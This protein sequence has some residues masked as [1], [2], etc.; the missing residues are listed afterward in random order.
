[1]KRPFFRQVAI[2]LSL[3]YL[4]TDDKTLLFVVKTSLIGL[5]LSIA[6]LLVV[7]GVI[8]GFQRDLEQRVLS[9]VPHVVLSRE[10]GLS[11]ELGDQVASRVPEVASHAAVVQTM[12]LASTDTEVH[13]IQL[14]GID[15]QIHQ[16]FTD[17]SPLRDEVAWDSLQSGAFRIVLGK[18]LAK[19]LDVDIGDQVLV[20]MAS[21]E[22]SPLG[23]F[24]RQKKFELV[25]LA[26]TESS[27]DSL[28]SYLHREDAAKLLKLQEDANAVYFHLVDPLLVNQTLFEIY[29]AANE[30]DLLASNWQSN[31][32]ALYEFLV[33][34]KQLLFLMLALLLI[35]ATFNLVSSMVMLVQSRR[36]DIAVLRTLGGNTS[37][38]LMSFVV[39]GL[40]ISAI[41][42]AAA[43]VLAY[44]LGLLLPTLYGWLSLLLG[45]TLGDS[46]AL[47][48]LTVVFQ[49][50]DLLRVVVL[51]VTMVAAGSLYP[52][53]R[54]TQLEPA[55]ILR[56][57]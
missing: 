48:R 23:F 15:P 19:R 11:G 42:L 5:V 18:N 37:L 33:R 44:L 32:G 36:D 22:I 27:L 29:L 57:D 28:I 45:V 34:F 7:Q 50:D 2:L 46:F 16:G 39:T 56:D 3:R 4:L 8:A 54:A 6:V 49:S 30:S 9:L 14:I 26:N 43:T 47:H 13:P 1:M 17:S 53:W 31:F 35:V 24:P 40:L 52:A 25:G 12:G 38:V 41:G 51:T 55:E 21:G 20:T 10:S